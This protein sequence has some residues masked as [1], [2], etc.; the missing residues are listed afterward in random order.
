MASIEDRLEEQFDNEMAQV[1]RPNLMIVGGTGVGKSSLINLIFGKSIAKVGTGQPVT[2]GCERYED[3]K[4][5]LVIFDTEGYE[6]SEGKISAGNFREKIIPEIKQRKNKALN[7]Q[8]H[9][10][11]YCLSVANHRITDFDLDNLRL[12]TDQLDIPVAVVLTQCDAEPVDEQGNGET[13]QIFRQVLRENGMTCE[14]F[15][16]CANN[17]NHDPELKLDLEK[18]IDW[19]STSLSNDSLRRS[20]VAAQIASLQA[21]R[22]EAM[23]IIMTYSAT[24]AASAGFNPIPM[25]DALLIVPQQIAMAAS[26]AKIY[27]IDSMGEIAVSMLKGQIISLMGRQLAA[28]LTKLIPVLGQFINA[29]VAGV[30]TGGLGLAL[31]EVYE[32][33]IEGYLKTGKA[34][35]WTKLLSSELFMQA[36]NSGLANW[37]ANKA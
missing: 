15:E 31:V 13:S 35:D 8:I 23:N 10:I 26:L 12:I 17:P 7:E 4:V 2:R 32:R 3:P 19:S 6:V 33:A 18:L 9:L 37:K 11:W 14:V 24:T 1:S 28:S 29:G 16:T 30:I 36:F 25:S 34:P 21:K 20:F 22:S 27:G 5:P